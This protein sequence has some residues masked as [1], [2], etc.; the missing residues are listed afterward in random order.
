MEYGLYVIT[1]QIA[2]TGRSH[3]HIAQKCMKN[4]ADVLQLR[5]KTLS[6]EELLTAAK[7]VHDITAGS[8]MALIVCDDLEAALS[9]GAEGL[10]IYESDLDVSEVRS[11][12]PDGFVIGVSVSDLDSAVEAEDKGADYI[13]WGPLFP[14]YLEDLGELKE[15]EELRSLRE[16]VSIPIVAIGGIKLFNVSETLAAG[17]DGVA[18]KTG[19]LHQ[20]DIGEA[21]DLLAKAVS[22]QKRTGGH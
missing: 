17:A 1:D 13:I 6:K 5:D 19:A 20:R 7:E 9:S 18:V 8:R 16:A 21:V 10:H 14:S 2:A 11:K 15:L 3:A 12:C 22:S 4:G